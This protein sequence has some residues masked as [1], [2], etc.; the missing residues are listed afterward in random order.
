MAEFTYEGRHSDEFGWFEVSRRFMVGRWS[1]YWY[2]NKKRK[3]DAPRVGAYGPFD[4]AK[5]AYD[6]AVLW[7]GKP[8]DAVEDWLH[9]E[10]RVH[11]GA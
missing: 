4:S 11:I 8:Q 6:A 2:R 7:R 1:F 3:G 10:G 5:E 9:R